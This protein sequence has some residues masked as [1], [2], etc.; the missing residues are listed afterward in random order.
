MLKLLKKE[1]LDYEFFIPQALIISFGHDLGK[2]PSLCLNNGYSKGNHPILS[3]QKVEEIFWM[4]GSPFWLPSA[5][6]MIKNH[7]RFT[8]DFL[9]LLLQKAD[10]LARQEEALAGMPGF[11]S[12]KW[13]DW[14]NPSGFLKFLLPHIN[15]VQYPGKW[16]AFSFGSVVYF[17][18]YAL[19]DWVRGYSLERKVLEMGLWRVLEREEVLRK[20]VASLRR[21]GFISD[22][23]PDGAVGRNYEV[24]MS[25][26]RSVK[27][28]LIPV[29]I[30]TFKMPTH[31]LEQK[32]MGKLSLICSV[33]PYYRGYST[34]DSF[35]SE[36]G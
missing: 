15:E 19:Y 11:R 33:R 28:F 16:E 6:E 24:R 22:Q 32:K 25:I 17:S 12:V 9:T 35:P 2:S 10:S 5:L 20:I 31:K 36:G 4:K 14:F 26:V 29:K 18:P 13:D 30:D 27:L 7:H 34:G 8:K 21:V 3:A 23:L 1:Y